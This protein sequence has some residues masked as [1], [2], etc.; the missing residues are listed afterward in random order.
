MT[1][2]VGGGAL[3]DVQDTGD[4]R[5]SAA[6]YVAKALLAERRISGPYAL[7]V[8]Q[9]RWPDTDPR[10][11]TGEQ[12]ADYADAVSTGSAFALEPVPEG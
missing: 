9:S 7:Q 1:Q 4:V 5:E 12:L 10:T 2:T 8:G 6:A 3:T 11:W